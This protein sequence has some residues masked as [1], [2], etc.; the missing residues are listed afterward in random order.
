MKVQTILSTGATSGIGRHA[1]LDLVAQGHRVFATGRRDDALE[2]LK[3]EAGVLPL[4]SLRL[5]VNDP[6]SLAAA[7]T[8]V[9]SRSVREGGR[10]LP[11]A[12]HGDGAV[13]ARKDWA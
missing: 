10:L 2:A 1:A 7:Q 6:A 13:R 11:R 8:E 12:T 9:D 3:V 4:E 5:D